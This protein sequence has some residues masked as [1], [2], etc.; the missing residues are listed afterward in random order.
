MPKTKKRIKKTGV[1][2]LPEE[3]ADC[4]FYTRVIIHSHCYENS[5][6]YED[7]IG[8]LLGIL[9]TEYHE[10]KQMGITPLDYYNTETDEVTR[11]NIMH[12]MEDVKN[13]IEITK[14]LEGKNDGEK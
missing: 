6:T 3:W 7:L 10:F 14:K 1:F 5:P 2:R 13:K 12:I 8:S 9:V 4:F 11:Q